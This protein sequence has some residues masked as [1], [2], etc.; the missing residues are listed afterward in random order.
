MNFISISFDAIK[1]TLMSINLVSFSFN[2]G[3]KIKAD[4]SIVIKNNNHLE[5]I[6][7][8]IYSDYKT[9]LGRSSIKLI[10]GIKNDLIVYLFLEKEKAEGI[11]WNLAVPVVVENLT[12]KSYQFDLGCFALEGSGGGLWSTSL[13]LNSLKKHSEKGY[14]VS[15]VPKVIPNKFLRDFQYF[16]S[17]LK[18]NNLLENSIDLINYRKGSFIWIYKK[19]QELMDEYQL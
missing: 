3:K 2:F 13:L 10:D 11:A 4:D 7:K 5:A 17:G 8:Q 16:D 18:I 12:E 1:N 9:T 14:K 15:V 19:Y 6:E